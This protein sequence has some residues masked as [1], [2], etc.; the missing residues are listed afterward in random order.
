MRIRANTV[1]RGSV[2]MLSLSS[3]N[4]KDTRPRNCPNSS[5]KNEQNL[6]KLPAVASPQHPEFHNLAKVQAKSAPFQNSCPDVAP[7]V[8]TP[9]FMIRVNH[10][11]ASGQ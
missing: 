6:R 4:I 3:S 11:S 2:Y 10:F 5:S 9:L 8:S 7:R 1:D